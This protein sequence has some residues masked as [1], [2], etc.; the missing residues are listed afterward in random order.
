MPPSWMPPIYTVV[1]PARNVLAA[2]NFQTGFSADARRVVWNCGA[3]VLCAACKLSPF[4]ACACATDDS[5]LRACARE[6]MLCRIVLHIN[7]ECSRL[8]LI[9]IYYN[10]STRNAAT[11]KQIYKCSR[12]DKAT[13]LS[14]SRRTS[15]KRSSRTASL[16]MS[17]RAQDAPDAI[18][19]TYKDDNGG[20]ARKA[21]GKLC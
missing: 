18:Q 4:S 2:Q 5:S 10:W 19:C 20:M 17:S 3:V 16:Q 1:A 13:P 12:P 9:K 8:A 21:L 15:H 11:H 7:F 14:F 6:S